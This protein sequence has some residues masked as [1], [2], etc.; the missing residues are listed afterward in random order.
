MPVNR[1]ATRATGVVGAA[2]LLARGAAETA[3]ASVAVPCRRMADSP[4]RLATAGSV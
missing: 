2:G 3:S 4:A 1:H